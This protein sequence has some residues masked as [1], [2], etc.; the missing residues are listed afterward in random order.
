MNIKEIIN[1]LFQP[2]KHW[3]WTFRGSE[4]AFAE[5]KIGDATFVWYAR[6]SRADR[7]TEWVIAF[8]QR[9]GTDTR[10]DKT[11]TG[12]SV[13]VLSTAT[14]ITRAFLKQYGDKITGLEFSS[15][16]VSRTKLYTRMIHKLLPDWKLQ[17]VQGS[18]STSLILDKPK[19]NQ[20]HLSEITKLKKDEYEVR[21]TT[22]FWMS[23]NDLQRLAEL[24]RYPIE[25][26]ENLYLV[27]YNH[28][29]GDVYI[30]AFHTEEK[31]PVGALIIKKYDRFPIRNSYMVD[32]IGIKRPYRGMGIAQAMYRLVMAKKPNGMGATLIAGESQT[33]G[34]RQNWK[35]LATNTNVE[36]LGWASIRTYRKDEISASDG[37]SQDTKIY[38]ALDDLYGKL[39]AQYIGVEKRNFF[40]R[41][42]FVFPVTVGKTQI[43]NAVKNSGIKIYHEDNDQ[44][45]VTGL[46][47][48]WI[49]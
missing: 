34:G 6:I 8:G 39:G 2:G 13:Q 24:K 25:G 29:K 26:Q 45:I 18:S 33:P 49:A 1:E 48:K 12:H 46:L 41:H 30:Y 23:D 3:S 42:Y 22:P 19:E 36:V 5:F 20:V 14:D 21:G 10:Y 17:K 32:V 4:E 47:A 31:Y 37:E 44:P 27:S 43:M 11:G 28:D 38:N 9:D 15:D 40:E 7:P 35:R 16:E